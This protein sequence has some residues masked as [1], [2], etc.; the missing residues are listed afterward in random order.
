[1]CSDSGSDRLGLVTLGSLMAKQAS[2]G[3]PNVY[4][5]FLKVD[6]RERER[7]ARAELKNEPMEVV[8]L[9][10]QVLYEFLKQTNPFKIPH[11]QQLPWRFRACGTGE[12]I[13][14]ET[15]GDLEKVRE[16]VLGVIRE[17]ISVAG[18]TKLVQNARN[19]A[20]E[21]KGV[22]KKVSA[23]AEAVLQTLGTERES[24]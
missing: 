17:K 7:H 13:Y 10:A 4:P 24:E 14:C 20:Q 19:K 8:L 21:R 1:M 18:V 9:R 3:I 11:G 23:R 16:L 12:D 22:P 5:L 6:T 15:I 2:V